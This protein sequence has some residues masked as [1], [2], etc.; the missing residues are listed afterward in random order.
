MT[1]ARRS[2][3]RLAAAFV[4][5]SMVI[6]LA[7][8]SVEET[9]SEPRCPGGGSTL[10]VAQSVPSA[11]RIPCLETLPDGWLVASV[12]VSH[13]GTEITL[14]SDRAGDGAATLRL[15]PA[16]DVSAAVS[17]P[18]EYPGV[19]RF[20]DIQELAPGFRASRFYRFDGGCVTWH[21]AFDADA[22]AT[23]AVALGDA[24]DLVSREELSEQ[25]RESFVGEGL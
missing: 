6:W 13:D 10:I 18:S 22:S 23:L 8:C 11:D 4:F 14:D 1:T 25:L 9:M 21:F 7:A 19:E 16:C 2:L 5:A 17:S 24:L 12:D 3:L 20:D 15:V